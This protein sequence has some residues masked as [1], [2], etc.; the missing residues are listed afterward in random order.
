[1]SYNLSLPFSSIPEDISS[2]TALFKVKQLLSKLA[3][4]FVSKIKPI[5]FI[6]VWGWCIIEAEI[7]HNQSRYWH[8]LLSSI[9]K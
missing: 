5:L 4:K 3:K 8:K 1:M 9:F 2:L 7:Q 6:S